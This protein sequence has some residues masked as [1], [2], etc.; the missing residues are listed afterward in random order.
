MTGHAVMI[1]DDPLKLVIHNTSPPKKASALPYQGRY[2]A[3]SLVYNGIWYYGTYCLGPDGAYKHNG[4]IWN[5]PNLGPM[6]GFQI[7]ARLRQDLGAVAAYGRTSVVSRAAQVSRSGEDGSTALRRFRPE[8]GTFAGRQGVRCSAWVRKRT[9]PSR[10]PASSRESR[11]S[12]SRWSRVAPSDFA[13]A[14]L[15][16]ITAD[17]VYLARVKPSPKT[18]NDLKAWEFFAG[19]DGAGR[20]VWT[21]PF[22]QDQAAGGMEQP[23]GVRHGH[24]RA[25][26]EEIPDVRHRRM[27][28]RGQDDL[29]H[30]RSRRH[31]RPVADGGLHEGLRGARLLSQFPQQVHQPRRADPVALL[32][33]E[34]QPRLEW[35]EVGRQSAGRAVW[36][37]FARG[38]TSYTCRR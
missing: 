25:G 23:H 16:W 31:H 26:T 30:P 37:V 33:H 38:P 12:R 32:F 29:L 7:S 2:P 8:H 28:D 34:F 36:L 20:P 5:W 10:G 35:R 4:F 13:H 1:G 27:A 21:E 3:G 18:I 9:I 19:Y 6:P 15:S 17:Q 14:N 24:V 22:R 11:A